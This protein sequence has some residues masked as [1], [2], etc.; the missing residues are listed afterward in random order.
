M[1]YFLYDTSH[2]FLILPMVKCNL[3][4]QLDPMYQDSGWREC[5]FRVCHISPFLF[6]KT[7]K[8]TIW[9]GAVVG[10]ARKPIGVVVGKGRKPHITLFPSS[11][12]SIPHRSVARSH[13]KQQPSSVARLRR[14]RGRGKDGLHRSRHGRLR[15]RGGVHVRSPARLVVDPPDD[16]QERHRAGPPG[17]PGGRRRQAADARRGGCQAPVHGESCRG[18]HGGPHAPAARLVQR[19]VVHDGGGQGRPALPAVPRRARVQVPDPQRGRRLHGGARAHE[20]GQG[21][22]GELVLPEGCGP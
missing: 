15:R 11:L 1:V 5:N 6:L 3:E 14:G 2:V 19:G 4:K 16:A 18:G 8:K 10:E 9:C 13:Q 7:K 20:P 12:Q 17:D 22:H 21:P